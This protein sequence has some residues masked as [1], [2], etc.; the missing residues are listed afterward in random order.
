[1]F[2]SGWDLIS[3]NKSY[4]TTRRMRVTGEFVYWS[5]RFNNES[6]SWSGKVRFKH[7]WIKENHTVK[8]FVSSD[9]DRLGTLLEFLEFVTQEKEND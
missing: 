9:L 1:M 6:S 4:D 5:R 2:E 3:Y 7:F 8:A